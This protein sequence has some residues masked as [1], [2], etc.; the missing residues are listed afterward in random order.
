MSSSW[1]TIENAIQAWVVAGTSFAAGKVIWSNG[2]GPRPAAPYIA[3][4]ASA[5]NI[6][7]GWTDTIDNP[8]PSAGEEIIR[9]HRTVKRL[10]VQVQ[11]F[12]GDA[13]Q[14]AAPANVLSDMED[15]A[16]LPSQ[17]ELFRTAGWMPVQFQP[18]LDLSG[19]LGGATFEPRAIAAC[20]GYIVGEVTETATY[21]QIV[22]VENEIDGSTFEVDENP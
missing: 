14:S 10:D 18:V 5:R 19:I 20:H 7:R 4:A 16:G 11:C 1:T 13:T 9:T 2:A 3:I 6:G 21:I 15:H 22:Q 12:G 8:A 17:R